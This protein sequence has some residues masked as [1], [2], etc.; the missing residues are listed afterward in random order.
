MA[1]E[2]TRRR[3]D[4]ADQEQ[5]WPAKDKDQGLIGRIKFA[6][7]GSEIKFREG[8][9]DSSISSSAGSIFSLYFAMDHTW[10]DALKILC[11]KGVIEESEQGYKKLVEGLEVED[12][13]VNPKSEL[14]AR[15][16]AQFME[17][18]LTVEEN[19]VTYL[20]NRYK[21]GARVFAEMWG[22]EDFSDAGRNMALVT[23]SV[24]LRS[25]DKL[26]E[27][28]YKNT[29]AFGEAIQ[30]ALKQNGFELEHPVHERLAIMILTELNSHPSLASL[31]TPPPEKAGGIRALLGK[32]RL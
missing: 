7:P 16:R 8:T 1:L 30:L 15:A 2:F 26:I 6:A 17:L 13:I 12:G 23:A 20:E 28:L 19:M 11:E 32:L 25:Q 10:S 24:A 3:I 27:N 21:A 5:D 4:R 14:E 29:V 31:Q 18:D 9:E 22:S